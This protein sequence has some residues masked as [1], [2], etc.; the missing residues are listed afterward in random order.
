[1]MNDV[2]AKITAATTYEEDLLSFS[3][4]RTSTYEGELSSTYQT[5]TGYFYSNYTEYENARYASYGNEIEKVFRTSENGRYYEVT[6]D[7]TDPEAE[8]ISGI[9]GYEIVDEVINPYSE[10]TQD[11]VD[12]ELGFASGTT[13]GFAL[14]T[15]LEALWEC[16]FENYDAEY[17]YN[18][19]AT[20]TYSSAGVTDYVYSSI[21]Y[22]SE[23]PSSWGGAPS[24][25]CYT[26]DLGY[27][28]NGKVNYALFAQDSYDSYSENYDFDLHMPIAAPSSSYYT[29]YTFEF[30]ELTEGE[31][32][33][34][35]SDIIFSDYEVKAYSDYAKTDEKTV[36]S[37]GD[38][39]YF[40]FEGTPETACYEKPILESITGDRIT[41]SSA[42]SSVNYIST[43]SAGTATFTFVSAAGIRKSIEIT[44]KAPTPTSISF[45]G[46]M[47]S[48]LAVNG[49]EALPCCTT[50]PYAASNK[51]NWTI[52]EGA[53]YA[54]ITYNAD[55]DAHYIK[56]LASGI[57]KV[58]AYAL[59]DE[60][61]TTP[62]YE[63][64]VTE[65]KS[66]AE[67][68]TILTTTNWAV[69]DGVIYNLSFNTDGTGAI[70]FGY[71][72]TMDWE[73]YEYV[74][75]TEKT[76]YTFNWE[77]DYAN[78]AFNITNGTWVNRME[79]GNYSSFSDPV[80]TPSLLGDKVNVNFGTYYNWDFTPAFSSEQL[81]A[82]IIGSEFYGYATSFH[83]ADIYFEV[84]ETAV[85]FYAKSYDYSAGGYIKSDIA[86]VE[87][88]WDANNNIVLTGGDYA[89]SL[90]VYGEYYD[91]VISSTLEVETSFGSYINVTFTADG[92]SYTVKCNG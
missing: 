34:T 6:T 29:E 76:L 13:D 2:I 72:R 57:V 42:G 19:S 58:Q 15:S 36:Y 65:P 62:V 30:G 61:I 69:N 21:S 91:I 11:E 73:T 45:S 7:A 39:I 24:V 81:H 25:Y 50:Q 8:T 46:S 64:E 87:Y 71:E 41:W 18:L 37:V 67:I 59:D 74:Y 55:E 47:P 53:D 4:T 89:Y 63:I 26:I 38:Y 80:I 5:K 78:G 88:T 22:I 1:M 84:G 43:S 44:V 75:A 12:A 86:E 52:V 33:Y 85:S 83:Y 49:T 56:G 23:V 51:H 54:E 3:Y 16:A 48:V 9:I 68:N 70:D 10:M 79:D 40:G 60:T 27:D 35:M 82:A 77:L 20:K 14:A 66:E 28:A 90:N 32:P 92:K 17:S 31:A